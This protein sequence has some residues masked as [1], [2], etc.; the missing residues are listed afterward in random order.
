MS[1]EEDWVSGTSEI[2]AVLKAC[3]YILQQTR[4]GVL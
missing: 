3:E 2:E 1:S 4:K